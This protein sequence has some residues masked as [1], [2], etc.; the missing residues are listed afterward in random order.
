M[1]A[2]PAVAEFRALRA[3]A[4]RR[5]GSAAPEIPR[6]GHPP[7]LGVA[8][9]SPVIAAGGTSGP[10]EAPGRGSGATPTSGMW[11]LRSGLCHRPLGLPAG[12]G[13]GVREVRIGLCPGRTGLRS[14]GF[15]LDLRRIRRRPRRPDEAFQ[16]PCRAGE[17]SSRFSQWCCAGLLASGPQTQTRG[18]IAPIPDGARNEPGRAHD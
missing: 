17:G 5:R 12:A 3:A 10:A 8:P 7:R 9:G 16:A 15:K 18:F 13:V 4:G 6:C 1:T 11:P 2:V 14:R